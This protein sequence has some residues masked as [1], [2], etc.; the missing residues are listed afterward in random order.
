MIKGFDM[1]ALARMNELGAKYYDNG[2]SDN[3]ISILK[4][5]GANLIRLRLF[6]NPYSL[7]GK[8]YGAGICDL[9]YLKKNIEYCRENN[10][11]YLLDFHYSDCWADPGKQTMPK[12]WIN[13]TIDELEKE[14]YLFTIDTL[15]QLEYRPKIVQIGNEITNGMLWPVG[16][17]DNFENLVRLVNAGIKAVN[18]F[19]SNIKTMIHLDNGTNNVMY[20]YWFDNYFRLGGIDFDYIGM[21]YYQIWNGSLAV[22]RKDVIDIISTYHKN[23]IIVE[24]AYPFSLEEYEENILKEERKGMAL[25]KELVSNL[26]YGVGIEGQNNYFIDLGKMINEIDGLDGFVYWGSELT[27]N[28]GSSWA[29]YEGIEYMKEKGPLGNEWANQA[30][31]DYDGEVL[32]VMKIISKI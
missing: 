1:S 24:T 2:V 5:Y 13:L 17:T 29:S 32:P 20:H 16:K 14:V 19:D 11:D 21:S 18:D 3:A 23:I 28:D 27:P 8:E 7:D 12:A 9:N 30:V 15:K 4:R 6:N 25:K 26:E 10:L 31:F 22:L